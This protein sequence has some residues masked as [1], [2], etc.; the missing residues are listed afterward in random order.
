VPQSSRN[1]LT[2]LFGQD[3][4]E[5]A[6]A[7]LIRVRV[8]FLPLMATIGATFA[9]FEPTPWRR[10]LIGGAVVVMATLTTIESIRYRRRGITALT[11][12]I[13][14]F[15][16]VSALIG[17]VTAT[18]G[19]FSP[20]LPALMIATAIVG[21]MIGRPFVILIVLGIFLPAIWSF[22]IV[23]TSGAPVPSLVPVI[24]GSVGELERGGAAWVFASVYTFMLLAL[25]RVSLV[26]RATLEDVFAEAVEARDRTLALHAEQSQAL[27]TLT[28]E[29]AHELKNPLTSVKGLASLLAKDVEGKPAERLAVLRREVDRMQSVL[30]EFLNFSRPLVPLSIS[31]VDLVQLARDVALLHEGSALDRAV[32]LK[33]EA[34]ERVWLRC[35]PRKVRQIAI[36]LVQNALEATGDGS[37]VVL[38]VERTKDGA[39]LRVIDQGRGIDGAIAERIFDAGVTS[40]EHG[41]GLGLAVARSLAR[42]H[43][44]E[45]TLANVE[46]GGCEA[47][48]ALP[49]QPPAVE[50]ER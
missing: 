45:L 50:E 23:H 22:A 35:D 46:T 14:L 21:V 31:E 44:G 18:G 40:K 19:L 42:Q 17:L 2:A 15:T 6:V 7:G 24:A 28:G 16:M 5:R 4:R 25:T 36:N 26:I 1:N 30:E 29:I 10:W 47:T 32:A 39:E 8:F 37:E 11:V 38:H 20:L 13:N 27:T 33:V 34:D 48:L 9:V 12:P 3:A 49:R 43:G 41:S